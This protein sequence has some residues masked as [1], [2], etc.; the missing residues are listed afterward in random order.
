MYPRSMSTKHTPRQSSRIPVSRT[1]VSPVGLAI[2]GYSTS[3]GPQDR[4]RP[5]SQSIS[6]QLDMGEGG[7]SPRSMAVPMR[8]RPV[9]SHFGGTHSPLSSSPPSRTPASGVTSKKQS[10][11]ANDSSPAGRARTSSSAARQ[12]P[13]SIG[14]VPG[15]INRPEGEAPWIATMYKPDPMLPPE[16]Q[17]L[18]TQ[19]RRL[20]EQQQREAEDLARQRA[21]ESLTAERT[22]RA[23]K[24]SINIAHQAPSGRRASEHSVNASH[25]SAR[26]SVHAG[27]SNNETSLWPASYFTDSESKRLSIVNASRHNSIGGGYRFTPLTHDARRKSSAQ[28]LRQS[29]SRASMDR[30]VLSKTSKQSL[31]RAVPD[32]EE[33]K[34]EPHRLASVAIVDE[35][36]HVDDERVKPESTAKRK[37]GCG[38]C[39]VM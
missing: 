29:G 30:K 34:S 16:Q 27:E 13:R 22:R 19:A 14:R 39:I 10:T 36:A 25:L 20:Q 26:S 8:T 31:S 21:Q 9:S 1:S 3:D 17:M 7:G 6:S 24:D 4:H 11:P 28:S 23:S 5:R 12:R 38:C 33:E 35:S 37:K 15:P 18:P 2:A 32:V